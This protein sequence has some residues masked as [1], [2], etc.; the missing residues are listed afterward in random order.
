MT[1]VEEAPI[2]EA[3]KLKCTPCTDTTEDILLEVSVQQA[4]LPENA[5]PVVLMTSGKQISG[6]R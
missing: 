5:D 4:L 1:N 3:I 2:V 6:H